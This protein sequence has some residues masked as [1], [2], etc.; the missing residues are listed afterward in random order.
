M[1][2]STPVNSRTANVTDWESTPSETALSTS[3]NFE[4]AEETVRA[5]SLFRA[6][7][8]MSGSSETTQETVKGRKLSLTVRGT[9]A[10]SG[11][12]KGMV[13]AQPHFPAVSVTLGSSG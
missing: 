12:I 9:S 4:M 2:T 7:R 3:E 6:V 11:T 1:G 5:Q 8:P 10:N 13:K